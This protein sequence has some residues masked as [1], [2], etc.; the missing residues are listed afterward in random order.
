MRTIALVGAPGSE[1]TRLARALVEKIN[2]VD[3]QCQNCPATVGVVDEYALQT[4][5]RGEYEI[6]LNAGYMANIDIACM[7]YRTERIMYNMEEKYMITCGT[8]VETAVYTALHFERTMPFQKTDEDKLRENQRFQA[9][10]SMLAT[11]YLDTFKYDVA[12]YLPSPQKP[13][14]ERWLGFER[15]LQAAFQVFATPIVPLMI[16]EFSDVD[17]LTD[18]RVEKVID[19]VLL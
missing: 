14:D 4:R 13:E 7:R 16:E 1:K 18:K 6:G 10:T 11:L 17:D 15:S 12:Y 8:V 19:D 2:L 5:D 3:P 9:C